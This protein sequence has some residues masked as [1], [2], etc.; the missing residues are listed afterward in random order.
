[1]VEQQRKKIKSEEDVES[2][3]KTYGRFHDVCIKE[4]RYTNGQY[5]VENLSMNLINTLKTYE[6]FFNDNG[7][8]QLFRNRVLLFNLN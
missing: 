1:M 4:L 6:L 3:M 8:V 2:L 7:L 5:I